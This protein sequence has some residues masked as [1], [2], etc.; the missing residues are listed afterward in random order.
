MNE[1]MRCCA[2]CKTGIPEEY[3]T[4][5]LIDNYNRA[6]PYMRIANAKECEAHF[7]EEC[8]QAIMAVFWGQ[9]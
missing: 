8:A 9:A 5:T 1:Y 3:H 4:M 7:C 2:R 6:E